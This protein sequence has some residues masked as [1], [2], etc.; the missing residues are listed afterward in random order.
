VSTPPL[1]AL[2][3]RHSWEASLFHPGSARHDQPAQHEARGSQLQQQQLQEHSC[4]RA[5]AQLAQHLQSGPAHIYRGPSDPSALPGSAGA[6]A[7]PGAARCRATSDST[8]RSHSSLLAAVLSAG[9]AASECG[10]PADSAEVVSSVM[11]AEAEAEERRLDELHSAAIQVLRYVGDHGAELRAQRARR[12]SDAMASAG[13][14]APA[15][16]PRAAPAAQP[17]SQGARML[18]PAVRCAA[19]AAQ[20]ESLHPPWSAQGRFPGFDAGRAENGMRAAGY[21]HLDGAAGPVAVQHECTGSHG[22]APAYSSPPRWRR[23][24][25]LHAPAGWGTR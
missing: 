14:A 8:P 2:G 18:P 13:S 17:G 24:S 11:D 15:A 6:S 16:A 20:R 7:A 4:V 22:C 19:P 12:H 1:R 21:A 5:L 9:R 25:L 10:L 23:E 3:S